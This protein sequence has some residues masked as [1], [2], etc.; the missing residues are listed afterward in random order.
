MRWS[1][2]TVWRHFGRQLPR[3]ERAPPGV[4]WRSVRPKSAEPVRAE[5]ARSSG[6][7][8][9]PRGALK[10]QAGQHYIVHYGP[11]DRAPVRRTLFERTYRRRDDGRYEKRPDIV[12]RYFTLSYPVMVE[13]LEGAELAQPGDWI[14]EG[15]AGEL[16]PIAPRDAEQKYEPA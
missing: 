5:L 16:W 10:Y 13:T 12:L 9:T 15:V 11:G 2:D 7:I 1:L 4:V 3:L 6:K 8:E 14:M